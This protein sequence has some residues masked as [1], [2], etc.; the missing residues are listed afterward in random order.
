MNRKIRALHMLILVAA[1]AGAFVLARA[2]SLRESAPLIAEAAERPAA[3][4]RVAQ[5]TVD[6]ASSITAAS[7]VSLALTASPPSTVE[8]TSPVAASAREI[9]S[10]GETSAP[11]ETAPPR[12]TASQVETTK[13]EPNTLSV[14]P[15]FGAAA[16]EDPFQKLSWTS[17]PVAVVAPA[18]PPPVAP[19]APP[20]PFTFIGLL[21]KGSPKPAAFLT[22]GEEL[23]VVSAGDDV[24]RT[25][26]VESLTATE[27]VFTYLPLNERQTI[28]LAGGLR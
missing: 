4:V 28:A 21:E 11:G 22:R 9:A 20:L 16:A 23:I 1:G 24:D 19:R 14:R 27:I 8:V 15:A 3:V 25:Y 2:Y 10:P 5:S 26:R 17:P 7:S 12:E 6:T 13:A 18:P